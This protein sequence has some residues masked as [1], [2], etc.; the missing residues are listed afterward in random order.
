[1]MRKTIKR[2]SIGLG[3]FLLM[4][5]AGVSLLLGTGTGRNMVASFVQ[6]V[7]SGPDFGLEIG[8]IGGSSLAD[9]QVDSIVLRDA[10]GPWLRIKD[11]GFQWSPFALF[12]GRLEASRLAAEQIAVLRLPASSEAASDK[13]SS[14]S[15][16]PIGIKLD[17]LA[18][19]RLDLD[20][21]ILGAPVVLAVSGN[22]AL[23]D[24]G[25]QLSGALRIDRRDGA[26]G[27][28]DASFAY[29]APDQNLT[30]DAQFNEPANGIVAGLMRVP[31]T[32]AT[33]GRIVGGGSLDAFKSELSLDAGGNRIVGGTVETEVIGTAR[34]I[35]AIAAGRFSYLVPQNLQELFD[36]ES[37]LVAQVDLGEEGGLTVHRADLASRNVSLNL[38]AQAD[39]DLN[40]RRARLTAELARPDGGMI[41]LPIG[42]GRIAVFENAK[43][44]AELGTDEGVQPVTANL[45]LRDAAL[46]E[47]QIDELTVAFSGA[48]QDAKLESLWTAL[49]GR[50]RA[51]IANPVLSDPKLNDAI[52]DA[53]LLDTRLGLS[54]DVVQIDEA[55][56]D[57]GAAVL[58]YQGTVSAAGAKGVASVA[59]SNFGRFSGLA[60]V[61]LA[62]SGTL[63]ATGNIGF[64]DLLFALALDG[65]IRDLAVTPADG[66]RQQVPGVIRITGSAARK[67]EGGITLDQLKLVGDGLNAAI[68]GV[69]DTNRAD[70]NGTVHI[71]NATLI[72]PRLAGSLDAVLSA[73]G[74]PEQASY[75]LKVTGQDFKVEGQAFDQ[76]A[77]SFVGAGPLAF[78][79]GELTLSGRF[80]DRDLTGRAD[81]ARTEA[82][83]TRIDNLEFAYGAARASGGVVVAADGAPNGALKMNIDDLGAFRTLAGLPL[84]GGF[85]GNVSFEP[86]GS[87]VVAVIRGTGQNL[88]VDSTQVSSINIDARVDN[89]M[90]APVAQGTVRIAGV[91][92][93]GLEIGNVSIDASASG[94]ATR[95]DVKTAVAGA[96]LATTA[97][98]A[99][100][101]GNVTVGLEK[102]QASAQG[103]TLS[104]AKPVTITVRDGNVTIP[105]AVMASRGGRI[106]VAGTAGANLDLR[107]SLDKVPATLISIVAPDLGAAGLISGSA[108]VKGASANPSIT[109]QLDWSGAAMAATRGAGLPPLAISARGATANNRITLDG[110][111][112]SAGELN[113]AVGGSAPM[114]AGDLALQ[115]K[116]AIPASLLNQMLGAGGATVRG[117]INLDMSVSGPTSDP[118]IAGLV[119]TSGAIYNDPG[120]GLVLNDINLRARLDGKRVVIEQLAAT[121][122]A[123]GTING[124]GNVSIDPA[125]GMPA[126]IRIKATAFKVNDKRMLDGELNAD[127]ALTGSLMTGPTLG[128]EI[129]IGRMNVSIPEQLPKSIADLNVTHVNAPAKVQARV[130]RQKAKEAS[131]SSLPITLDITINAGNQIFIR[132][133]GLDVVLGGKVRIT[134][135]A[136]N[137]VGIGGFQ[138]RTGNLSILGKRL[139]FTEGT[140]DFLG[141]FDPEL[142]FAAQSS[143]GGIVAVVRVTGK[144]S[145][146]KFSFDSTPS[147]PQDEVLARLLFDKPLDQLSPMQVAQLSMEVARL[148]GIG[149]GPGLLDEMRRSLGVDVLEFSGDSDKNTAAVS[150][151]KYVS[152]NVY[153]GVKQST[154]G[155]SSAVV[156]LN[157]TKNIQLRGEVDSEGASKLGIGVE[158]EY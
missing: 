88:V 141:S 23:T 75:S 144:A 31:G 36:G 1:M 83:D 121:S 14:S 122:S 4:T 148:G 63:N 104:L 17:E 28:L 127:L 117:A 154:D 112:K 8:H 19:R 16:P 48:R 12:A 94:G 142:N 103:E 6:D 129:N 96:N 126:D 139:V 106:V 155:T 149:G 135:T 10:Q 64:S 72:N 52:G 156:D 157:V 54:G 5:V 107:A 55:S 58:R 87:D 93:G 111:I 38:T 9:L 84:A 18:I 53:I 128:G 45:V 25:D 82:G 143:A 86:Q 40:I 99:V 20:A 150:A 30:I 46:P 95:L 152:D 59:A 89:L 118:R 145:D 115:L 49:R 7:V 42:E 34:R 100:A 153:V 51:T 56:L 69:V 65:S 81:I 114:G 91:K 132:G 39:T 137:P 47:G 116:G 123:G 138:L 133:R 151:G 98:I 32:P 101:G 37:R 120:L 50:L 134:G 21:P 108:T 147:L 74:T 105:E 43:L 13:Q 62:G 80:Q 76:P 24:P 109:Y 113:L 35:T 92:S 60:G 131:S 66:A 67:A 61:D 77:I 15:L 57:L 27:T 70:L 102:L 146:P 110:N 68:D 29:R 22:A 140:V 97:T 124:S 158:W 130:D 79:R 11:L 90:K 33:S 26:G 2:G 71:G 3:G 125:T 78:P 41:S 119:T 73:K 44:T 85:N 136:A